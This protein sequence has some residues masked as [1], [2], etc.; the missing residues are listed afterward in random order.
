MLGKEV[1]EGTPQ[2]LINSLIRFPASIKRD[3]DTAL[4]RV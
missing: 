2:K 4:A 3:R 1:K